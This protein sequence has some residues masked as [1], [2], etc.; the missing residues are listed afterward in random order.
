ML[1]GVSNYICVCAQHTLNNLLHCVRVRVRMRAMRP[2]SGCNIFVCVCAARCDGGRRGVAFCFFCG[3]HTHTH[4]VR[5]K[6]LNRE[7][8][9]ALGTRTGRENAIASSPHTESHTHHHTHTRTHNTYTLP[10]GVVEINALCHVCVCVCV[11]KRKSICMQMRAAYTAQHPAS[12]EPRSVYA[13]VPFNRM[14]RA[15]E[16]ADTCAD[17]EPSPY[18]TE[19]GD[20]N[21]RKCVLGLQPIKCRI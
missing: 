2:C 1:F 6:M 11:V 13:C 20:L 14:L 9:A 17:A 15:C 10:A 8:C 4:C 19:K 5:A 12:T 16:D 21:S 18:N 3:K 7:Q